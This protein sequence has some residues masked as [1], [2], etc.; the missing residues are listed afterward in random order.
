MTWEMTK[1]QSTKSQRTK[2]KRADIRAQ[3]T[4]HKHTC[5]IKKNV[6][7]QHSDLTFRLFFICEAVKYFFLLPLVESLYLRLPVESGLLGTPALHRCLSE[8]GRE[9][10]NSPLAHKVSVSFWPFARNGPLQ[11]YHPL[12]YSFRN[13]NSLNASFQFACYTVPVDK[14]TLQTIQLNLLYIKCMKCLSLSRVW[15]AENILTLLKSIL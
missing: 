9:T 13:M 14:L 4:T 2:S 12:L 7:S 5:C 10:A 8:R 15:V 6:V 1:P 11:H 3:Y